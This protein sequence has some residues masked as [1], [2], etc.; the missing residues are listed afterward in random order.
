MPFCRR[1]ANVAIPQVEQLAILDRGQMLRD[2]SPWFIVRSSETGDA[3]ESAP[4]LLPEETHWRRWILR[5]ID[6]RKFHLHGV[7]LDYLKNRFSDDPEVQA[8][9]EKISSTPWYKAN[10][11]G[12]TSR[13]PK[14]KV[15]ECSA[16]NLRNAR[17]DVPP[18]DFP[19][20]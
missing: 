19:E 18:M 14:Q 10:G 15:G 17:Q 6:M 12:H 1:R 13:K 5:K 7:K 3:Q 2:M 20:A 9:M 4:R 8:R 16:R 11:K